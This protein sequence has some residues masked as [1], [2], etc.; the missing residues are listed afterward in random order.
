MYISYQLR[1]KAI[2]LVLEILKLE[3][4]D[5]SENFIKQWSRPYMLYDDVVRGINYVKRMDGNIL[6][7]TNKV[8]SKERI[9]KENSINILDIDDLI[10]LSKKYKKYEFMDLVT[11]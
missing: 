11:N 9:S 4:Y 1:E 3:G 7:Y 2:P 6:V 5:V 10:N 8:S